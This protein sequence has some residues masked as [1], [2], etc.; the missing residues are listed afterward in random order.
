VGAGLIDSLA[1]PGANVTGQSGQAAELKGKQ[2]QLLKEM[3]P[4]A[5]VV[6]VLLNPDTPYSALSL[7][8]LRVAAARDGTRL[9]L[10]EAR[11]PDEFSAAKLEALVASGAA[12]LLVVEDP[13]TGT[14]RDTV[15]EL[16]LRARL[17][18][19]AG[20]RDYA[21]AGALM[22]YGADRRDTWRRTAMYVD[23]ILRGASPGDLPVE[24]PTRFQLVVNLKTAE[25]LGLEVPPSLL[26]RADEVIE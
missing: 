14:I 21:L 3:V 16:A 1:R 7:E 22:S 10:L 15:V 13:L 25:T 12:S 24:Q 2:L 4:G 19:L 5:H 18:T 17:P 23:R 11:R 8:Q 9:E 20:P 6:G 26:A